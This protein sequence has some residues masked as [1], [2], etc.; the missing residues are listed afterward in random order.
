MAKTSEITKKARSGVAKAK[1][2][3]TSTDWDIYSIFVQTKGYT[4]GSSRGIF[5]NSKANEQVM[6]F[7]NA[8]LKNGKFILPEAL[9]PYKD[10]VRAILVVIKIFTSSQ[11]D[12]VIDKIIAVIDL[13]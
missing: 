5:W 3:Q 11:V 13:L 4:P 10:L 7:Y 8:N 12:K 2:L 6:R 9:V 1:K